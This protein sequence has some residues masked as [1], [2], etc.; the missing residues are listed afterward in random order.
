M[1]TFY[2]ILNNAAG[3]VMIDSDPGGWP[4]SPISSRSSRRRGT[5]STSTT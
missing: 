2:Q 5:S 3:Y 1:E 4:Q